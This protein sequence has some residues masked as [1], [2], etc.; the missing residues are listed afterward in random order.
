MSERQPLPD[1]DVEPTFD[2]FVESFGGELV[3]AALP[4]NTNLPLN[5]DYF[6]RSRTIVAE[7]KCLEKD[8]LRKEQIGKKVEAMF[9]KWAKQG[10]LR[11]EHFVGNRVHINSLGEDCAMEVFKLY[12]K[13]IKR[14]VEKANRQIRVTKE[15]FGLADAKGLLI[16][17]NDGNYALT[18]EMSMSI[19]A[20][21][22]PNH[23]SS[24]D[25]FIYFTPNMRLAS[26]RYDRQANIWISGPSSRPSANAVDSDYMSEIEQGWTRYIEHITGETVT[27][28][29]EHDPDTIRDLRFVRSTSK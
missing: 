18:L 6:F 17:A 16:L 27:I 8:Y 13:P 28:F 7:L 25:S 9:Y 22:L 20:R 5:A 23:Y 4:S 3:R 14:A 19:L 12:F 11:P 26:N 1:M 24:I 10:R 2:S 15:Y 21:L 29:N